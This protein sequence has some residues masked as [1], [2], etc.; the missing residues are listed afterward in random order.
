MIELPGP[1]SGTLVLDLKG[2]HGPLDAAP[3]AGYPTGEGCGGGMPWRGN[4]VRRR[5]SAHGQPTRARRGGRDRRLARTGRRRRRATEAL[6]RDPRQGS[7]GRPWNGSFPMDAQLAEPVPERA[8]D[9]GRTVSFA[10]DSGR[11][12]GVGRRFYRSAVEIHGA[13][14]SRRRRDGRNHRGI[15]LWEITMP[16]DKIL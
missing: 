3:A 9:A 15:Q 11:S 5:N 7:G 10:G 13:K 14:R 16:P 4:M 2:K 12:G 1:L 6:P 8:S